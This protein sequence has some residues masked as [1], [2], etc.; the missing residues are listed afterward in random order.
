MYDGSVTTNEFTDW[1]GICSSVLLSNDNCA[2]LDFCFLL[3]V[4][5]LLC[6][7]YAIMICHIYP[8]G[9]HI[10]SLF[11]KEWEVTLPSRIMLHMFHISIF[12]KKDLKGGCF[13]SGSVWYTYEGSAWPVT[14]GKIIF[15][16]FFFILLWYVP[17]SHSLIWNILLSLHT[18]IFFPPFWHIPF[19]SLLLIYS[20]HDPSLFPFPSY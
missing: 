5:F 2:I 3:S 8:S 11:I 18:I 16:L 20:C 19:P 9:R 15:F 1:T 12:L 10:F 6:G 4:A 17:F 7:R 14:I 13:M